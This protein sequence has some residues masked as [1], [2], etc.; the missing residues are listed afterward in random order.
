MGDVRLGV[1]GYLAL[2]LGSPAC[3][4]GLMAPVF[5]DNCRDYDDGEGR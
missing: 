3:G 2:V 5:I 4:T 1:W